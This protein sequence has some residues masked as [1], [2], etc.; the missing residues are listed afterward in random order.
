MSLDERFKECSCFA[1][2]LPQDLLTNSQKLRLYAFYKHAQLGPAPAEAPSKLNMVAHA[3]V[4]ISACP[5]VTCDW[6]FADA[7]LSFSDG[8]LSLCAVGRMERCQVAHQRPGHGE[9]LRDHG[10]PHV[11]LT[12]SGARRDVAGDGH[13]RPRAGSVSRWRCSRC[14]PTAAAAAASVRCFKQC[15]VFSPSH[16][17]AAGT[18]AFAGAR[19]SRKQPRRQGGGTSY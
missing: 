5:D 9:L 15:R 7:V 2:S 19:G 13:S 18:P 14:A 3:K 8:V 12:P 11:A 1:N 16:C 10:G 6:R 4:C 17:Q